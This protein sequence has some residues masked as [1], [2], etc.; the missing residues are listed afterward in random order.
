MGEQTY[1]KGNFQYEFPLSDGSAVWL[2]AGKYYTPNGVSLA[3]VGITPDIV[4]ELDDEQFYKLYFDQLPLEEDDQI[5]AAL[6]AV[7]ESP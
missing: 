3:G 4:V 2:S 5:Q 7:W 6:E 1:G